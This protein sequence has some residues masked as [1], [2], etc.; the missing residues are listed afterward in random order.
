MASLEQN[1]DISHFFFV[2]SLVGPTCVLF[3]CIVIMIVFTTTEPLAIPRPVVWGT[4]AIIT[5][6]SVIVTFVIW[7]LVKRNTRKY[8]IEKQQQDVTLNIKL[9]FL[10]TFGFASIF[11]FAINM[12]ANIDCLLKDGRQ[13]YSIAYDLSIVT[14][15]ID[16]CFCIGQLGFLSLYGQFCFRPSSLINYGISLMIITHLLHWF[17]M[18][19][20]SVIYARNWMPS[21]LTRLDDCFRSS[22]ITNIS[23]DLILYINPLI[24]EYSLLSVTIAVGMFV[25]IF[26][27]NSVQASLPIDPPEISTETE[28]QTT[29]NDESNSSEH[30]TRRVSTIIAI[31]SGIVLSLPYLMTLTFVFFKTANLSKVFRILSTIFEIEFLALL[32]FGKR[33]FQVQFNDVLVK[34]ENPSPSSGYQ[35][36]LIVITSVAVGYETFGAIA[37]LMKAG[38]LFCFLLF[39]N[40]C[41]KIAVIMIQTG[42]ILQMK[43]ISYKPRQVRVHYFK[44]SRI[45][46]CIFVMNISRWLY[47][48][49]IIGQTF[50]ILPIQLEFYGK[51]YWR[52]ISSALFP[53]NVFYRLLTA[54]EMYE[55]Y[56]HTN[57]D[58]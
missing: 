28:D 14:N 48:S 39:F 9:V 19:F 56:R 30:L 7:F 54:I 2:N 33:Q 32:F 29:T 45:F 55:L 21:N 3:M 17:K 58:P 4:E 51:I 20:D 44:V 57:T 25:N 11:H 10:W 12:S 41:L 1:E 16:I 46:L 35:M 50:G 38:N 43:N 13:P 40:K 18:I 5:L 24:T 26:R 37:G 31:S 53:V 8:L 15:L 23:H 22:N 49:F 47:D 6:L 42:F 52:T 36:T 34:R 27:N